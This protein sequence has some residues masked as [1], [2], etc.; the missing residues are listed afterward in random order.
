M[1][2]KH[3]GVQTLIGQHVKRDVPRIHVPYMHADHKL[4]LVV[5]HVCDYSSSLLL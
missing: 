1:S 3:I 4:H 2:E 5:V